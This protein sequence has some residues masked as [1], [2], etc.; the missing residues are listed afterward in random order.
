MKVVL[1][2]L[3]LGLV[4]VGLT[5]LGILLILAV[6][7][8]ASAHSNEYLATIKGDHGGMLRMAEMY[9]FELMIKNGE[10]HV[11]VTDHGDKPQPTKGASGSLRILAGNASVNVGLKADGS[12]ELAAHDGRINASQ[13][14]HIILNITMPGQQPMQVRYAMDPHAPAG[15]AKP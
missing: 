5:L 11:W 12:N 7:M 8:A 4:S 14:S 3:H 2:P 15:M 6:P 9:H 10:A 1:Q 13:A